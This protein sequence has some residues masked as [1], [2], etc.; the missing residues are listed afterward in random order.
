MAARLEPDGVDGH[1]SDL[2]HEYPVV[3]SR[4]VHDPDDLNKIRT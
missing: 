4:G 1:D 3:D 2:Q